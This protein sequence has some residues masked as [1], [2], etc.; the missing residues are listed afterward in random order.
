[1]IE[2]TDVWIAADLCMVLEPS[3]VAASFQAV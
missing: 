3:I 1:M 2:I